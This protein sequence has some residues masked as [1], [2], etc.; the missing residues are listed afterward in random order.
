MSICLRNF[1]LI[2]KFVNITLMISSERLDE[3]KWLQKMFELKL[4]LIK[5]IIK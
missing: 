4:F 1:W 2:T 3:L 5:K